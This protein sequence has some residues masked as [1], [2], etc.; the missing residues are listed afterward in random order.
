[1]R[2][3]M[4]ALLLLL[5][6]LGLSPLAA[7]RAHACDDAPVDTVAILDASG[8][9]LRA[10][11]LALEAVAPVWLAAGALAATPP[12]PA[13]EPAPRP[14]RTPRPS[15]TP[16]TPPA[17]PAPRSG[18]WTYSYS[19]PTPAAAP[20]PATPGTPAMP[21]ADAD[22][23]IKKT[24]PARANAVVIVHNP[25]GSIRLIGWAR[26]EVAISCTLDR[27]V[28]RL[29]ASGLDDS[30]EIRIEVEPKGGMFGP[31]VFVLPA[32]GGVGPRG[33]Q[34]PQTVKEL[35]KQRAKEREAQRKQLRSLAELDRLKAQSV[36]R[37]SKESA[38]GEEDELD[39]LSGPG[40]PEADL[41][42]YVPRLAR[43]TVETFGADVN[44]SGLAG[45]VDVSSL[46]GD[47]QLEGQFRRI[48]AECVTCEIEAGSTSEA[49]KASTVSGN[50]T[51]ALA[52]GYVE[53]NT[54]SGDVDLTGRQLSQ[55]SFTSVSGNLLYKGDVMKD[56]ALYFETHNGAIDLKLTPNVGAEFDLSSITGEVSSDL[57][58]RQ[59]GSPGGRDA[60][61]FRFTTG[62]GGAR[63]SA[64]SFGGDITVT[65]H[66][67]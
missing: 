40:S 2:K 49:F 11:G 16:P 60:R 32:P 6:L 65:T 33:A 20:T 13:A 19:T 66:K 63:I 54:V 34:P 37:E 45:T 25:N 35:Q 36:S 53:L 15:T 18:S 23:T 50:I 51:L 64:K 41:E 61:Q 26:P 9:A 39:A 42:V 10:A 24:V 27:S 52:R 31:G 56:G 67:P 8:R 3:L 7:A 22:D 29:R 14:A 46:S 44:T 1:M 59:P 47:M 58:A 4:L 12:T 30:S 17:A 5:P 48:D 21:G 55:G 38:E 28:T 57:P 43:L 62:A